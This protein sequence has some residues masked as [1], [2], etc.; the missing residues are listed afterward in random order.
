VKDLAPIGAGY[1][2]F[3]AFVRSVNI[4]FGVLSIICSAPCIAL[5]LN[6]IKYGDSLEQFDSTDYGSL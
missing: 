3:Y 1:T 5:A 6:Q 2:M 4:M